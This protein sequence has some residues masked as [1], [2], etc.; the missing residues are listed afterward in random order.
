MFSKVQDITLVLHKVLVHL[1][2]KSIQQGGS[3]SQSVHFP[4][5]FGIITRFH[6]GILDLIIQIT[7]EDTEQHWAQYSLPMHSCSF[8]IFLLHNIGMVL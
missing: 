3:P 6:Q 1:L 5:Q 8:L 7:Y 4:S 2:F